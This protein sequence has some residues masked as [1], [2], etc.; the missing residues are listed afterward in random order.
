MLINFLKQS[1]L[2]IV[3]AL[4]FGLLVSGIYGQLDPII[5]KNE[6]EKLERAM[7]ELLSSAVTFE[8]IPDET[9]PK[10]EDVL[11]YIGKDAQGEVAG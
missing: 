1:W 2:V 5:K 6:R 9:D 4:V 8:S 10:K 3:A 7:R 11:Y